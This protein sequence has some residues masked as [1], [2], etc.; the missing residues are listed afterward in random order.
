LIRV[1]ATPPGVA[2]NGGF[3]GA[4]TFAAYQVIFRM[5]VAYFFLVTAIVEVG[6]GVCFLFL[7]A[8][9]FELL[10]GVSQA[11]PEAIFVGRITGAALLSLGVASGLGRSAAQGPA[12]QGLLTGLLIYNG[13]AAAL[14]GYAGLGL[15]MVGIALWPAVVL[16]IALAGWCVACLRIKP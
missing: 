11:A 4:L 5:H 13:A 9:L 3:S 12:R 8:V 2:P 1:G 10:L 6:A 15:S 14:L 7:P 16:H